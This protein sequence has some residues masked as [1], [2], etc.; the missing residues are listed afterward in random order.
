MKALVKISSGPDGIQVQDMPEPSLLAGHVII[1]VRACGVC[2]TDLHIQSGEYPVNPPVILGHEFSGCVA[3]VAPDVR[4]VKVGQRVTSLVYFTVCGV[5][6]FCRTGQWNL[7]AQR[8]SVGSGVHGAFTRYVMVPERNVRLIPDSL[9]FVAAAVTEPLACCAHGVLEKAVLRPTDSALVTG[10]G[11][12]GLL[13]A[14]ILRSAGVRVILAGTRA[15]SPRLDLARQLGVQETVIV[16][17]EPA[18]EVIRE[19]TGGVGPD[20]VFECSGAAAAANLGLQAARRGGQFIQLGLFGKPVQI[21]WDQAIFKEIVVHNSFASTTLSWDYALQLL[22]D[23]AVKT[24]PLVSAVW[25]LSR[26]EEAFNAF[27][28]RQGIKYILTPV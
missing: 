1:E 10:P 11:A 26:W 8:K 2:G 23:G 22:A 3:E 24:M 17:S 16:D 20:L 25:P 27:R 9:D 28:T 19:K 12:I 13:T 5:C 18:L 14:Q 21:D 15:D 7:C 4:Q 6:R